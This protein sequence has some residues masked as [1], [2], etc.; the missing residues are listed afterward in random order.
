MASQ[1]T[2]DGH[3]IAPLN[4]T[5]PTPAFDLKGFQFGLMSRKELHPDAQLPQRGG[6]V[7]QKLLSTPKQPAS[8][9]EQLK[10]QLHTPGGPA[11]KPP[12][13]L[14]FPLTHFK[15][16]YAG[17]GFNMIW[18]PSMFP[19]P[20]PELSEKGVNDNILL[21]N[22]TTEQWTFGPTLGAIKNRGFD[23]QK[24]IDLTGLAYMQTVQ[25]VTNEASGLGDKPRSDFGSG[26]HFEPGMWLYVP[27]ADFQQG[28]S[29]V[30]MA[31]IP[32]GTTINAQGTLPD[33][34]PVSGAPTIKSVDTTPFNIGSNPHQ[35][36]NFFA[37]PMNDMGTNPFR[38]PDNLELFDRAG[39][40][41]KDIIKDPNQVL[42][43]AL[44]G[45][46]VKEHFTFEVSTGHTIPKLNEGAN[47]NG[48]GTANISF[49][50]GKQ[51]TATTAAPS[52][53]APQG[54]NAHAPFMS[55]RWW[56]E[57][58]EYEITLPAI[59][60][61]DT[62]Q[63]S[64]VVPK[65]PHEPPTPRFRIT[66]PE[67]VNEGMKVRIPGTQIQYSQ[68]VHLNFGPFTW[69]HVSVATLVPTDAQEYTLT[70]NEFI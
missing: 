64:P 5:N 66:A 70:G 31:T 55:S 67:G 16:A 8:G 38:K 69:P 2:K 3:I 51:D 14:A 1:I 43:N 44:Q 56:I 42:R 39:T 21:L 58:I 68:M 57:T 4:I 26:I 28:D 62:V 29:I 59:R 7:S 47:L 22:L 19:G 25:N 17:N 63:I 53:G 41:N 13:G 45:L 37:A 12:P 6:P 35:T 27:Q 23:K 65:G 24:D 36:V 54:Q 15:G 48:G 9:G 60:P 46:E 18:V 10:E 30:R 61:N 52:T 50:A 49:L 11:V 40:I 32:H 20:G 34:T 33:K